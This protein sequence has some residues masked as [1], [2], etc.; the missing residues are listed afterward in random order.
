MPRCFCQDGKI[1]CNFFV[2]FFYLTDVFPGDGGLIVI[3]GSHKSKFERPKDLFYQDIYDNDG[4]VA[5]FAPPG[6]TNIIPR[7]GD[8]AIIS[9][10][11]THRALSWRLTNRDR[12]F[13]I[14][15]CMPQ[16]SAYSSF[17]SFPDEIKARLSPETLELLEAASYK[18]V[19]KI[20][21]GNRQQFSRIRLSPT[22]S[23][24]RVN[25]DT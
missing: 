7:A 13:L 21:E 20:V 5:D 24:R 12:R 15:R 3:P 11:L 22:H 9:E 25:N 2:V 16:Y 6:V 18:H 1:Y 8:V 4:Y 17:G 14:L 10:L 19:K 23:G